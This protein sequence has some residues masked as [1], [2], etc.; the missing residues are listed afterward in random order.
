MLAPRR[1][2]PPFVTAGGRR[3]SRSGDLSQD[4]GANEV[5]DAVLADGPVDILV[6]N[7]GEYAHRS[8]TDASSDDWLGAYRINV[9]WRE[10]C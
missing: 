5:A 8:W 3:R 2:S 4:S 9:L 1:S 10:C 6:N 7:A